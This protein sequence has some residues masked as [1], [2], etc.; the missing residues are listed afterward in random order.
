MYIYRYIY[1]HMYT[2]A[3]GVERER[4]R[5]MYILLLNI[6]NNMAEKS[7]GIPPTEGPGLRCSHPPEEGNHHRCLRGAKVPLGLG[8]KHQI[9]GGRNLC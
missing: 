6:K 9:P 7:R 1:I 3:H 2:H 4:D 5:D 8:W